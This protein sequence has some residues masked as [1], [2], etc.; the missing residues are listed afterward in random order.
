MYEQV[1]AHF[2]WIMA[3]PVQA[4]IMAAK[5]H[6]IFLQKYTLDRDLIRI[7]K[8]HEHASFEQTLC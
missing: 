4:K 3:N 5:T 6:K 2:A 7:A 1:K 8:M